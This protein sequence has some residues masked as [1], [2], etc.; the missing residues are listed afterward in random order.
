MATA[1]AVEDPG[2]DSASV[3]MLRIEFDGSAAL[4]NLVYLQNGSALT[5]SGLRLSR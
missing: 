4:D 1:T 5:R 3:V 2:F